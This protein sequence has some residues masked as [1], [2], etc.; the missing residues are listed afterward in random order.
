MIHQDTYDS[1]LDWQKAFVQREALIICRENKAYRHLEAIVEGD[2]HEASVHADEVM[3]TLRHNAI[4]EVLEDGE[5]MDSITM[6]EE[7]RYMTGGNNA[8]R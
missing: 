1:L 7:D 4:D 2:D 3:C 8:L 6:T 5:F